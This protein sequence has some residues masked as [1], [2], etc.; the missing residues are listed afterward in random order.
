ME[1]QFLLS[2]LIFITILMLVSFLAA[3]VNKG[4]KHNL[5]PF[6]APPG[7]IRI[8]IIGNIHH[9]L[10]SLPHRRLRDLARRHGPIMLLRLGQANLVVISSREAAK[11]VMKAHDP[12]FAS[13]PELLA[14]KILTYDCTGVAFSPYG[15]YQK[16]LK[17]VCMVELLNAKRVKYF[18][19]VRDQEVENLVRDI[20]L[21][22]AAGGRRPINLSAKFKELTN[23]LIVRTAIGSKCRQQKRLSEVSKEMMRQITGFNMV[24]MFPSLGFVDV[25]TGA[26]SKLQRLHHDFDEILGEIIKEHQ[27]KK[28]KAASDG[29]EEEE[30]LVHV[31]L[32]LKECG[33]LNI[34]LTISNVK[35]FI[36]VSIY[37]A[38]AKYI[39]IFSSLILIEDVEAADGTLPCC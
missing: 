27:E 1:L 36:L 32:R 39:K 18:S 2:P 31:L 5:P 35:A 38:G 33:D 20:T 14:L 4:S 3:A 22:C 37:V 9:L 21:S 15:E 10:F 19:Y 8:P 12:K 7:P 6:P 30:D 24:D 28:N 23:V 16:Q 17:K 26:S 29:K 11:D 34:P 13:R 25:V